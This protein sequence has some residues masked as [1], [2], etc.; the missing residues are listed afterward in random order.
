M[1]GNVP[2][3]LFDIDSLA[4]SMN[5]EPIVAEKQ[6]N[7]IARTKDNIVAGQAEKKKEPE[8]EYILIPICTTD[9]LISQGPKDS[10]VDAGKKAT[11][12]DESRVS[13]NDGQDDLVTRSEF[14]RL[15]QQERQ[16]EH[17]NST[18]SFNTVSSH[19]STAGPSFANTASPP[20]ISAV[21]TPACTNAFEEHPFC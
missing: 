4:I 21:R 1:E 14:E 8:Q 11:E 9:P 17:I 2:E 6:T 19:V 13:D 5:Y 12:V 20:L 15:L 18:N 16:T 10:T 3:W 7:G